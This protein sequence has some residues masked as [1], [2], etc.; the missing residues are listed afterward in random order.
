MNLFR[1]Q[2]ANRLRNSE[3]LPDNDPESLEEIRKAL[4]H[5]LATI[6]AQSPAGAAAV[7]EL[8]RSATDQAHGQDFQMDDDSLTNTSS[9]PTLTIDTADLTQLIEMRYKNQSRESAESTRTKGKGDTKEPLQ[10]S[11]PPTER[12]L[13]AAKIYEALRLDAEQGS[14]TGLNRHVRHTTAS[15]ATGNAANAQ[16]VAQTGAAA[17]CEIMRI[18]S[19]EMRLTQ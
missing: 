19:R 15:V 11:K 17:V 2:K 3:A 10:L 12:Q 18:R 13:L 4:L 8:V 14:S 1:G 7:H 6:S 16:A 5:A 9:S